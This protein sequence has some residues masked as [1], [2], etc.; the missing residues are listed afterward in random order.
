MQLGISF[1]EKPRNAK[2]LEL[3]KHEAFFEGLMGVHHIEALRWDRNILVKL[4][5]SKA[6]HRASEVETLHTCTSRAS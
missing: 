2:T 6:T 3:G 4:R 1:P 5:N